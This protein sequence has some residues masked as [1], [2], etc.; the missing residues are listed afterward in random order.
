MISNQQTPNDIKMLKFEHL[1]PPISGQSDRVIDR[2]DAHQHD[3][4]W[5][6]FSKQWA[7]VRSLWSKTGEIRGHW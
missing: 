1:K 7:W 2:A 4:L 6:S 3:L 5:E